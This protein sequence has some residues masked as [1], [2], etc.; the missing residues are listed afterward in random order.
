M[1]NED[2]FECYLGIAKNVQNTVYLVLY[3]CFSVFSK[4][5]EIMPLNN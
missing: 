3:N 2:A 5:I 1:H 4:Y